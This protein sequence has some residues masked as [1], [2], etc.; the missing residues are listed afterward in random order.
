MFTLDSIERW[1]HATS[2][3]LNRANRRWIGIFFRVIS[4]LGNGRFWYAVMVTLPVL[5]GLNALRISALMMLVGII[6]AAVYAVI[7]RHTQRLR[8]CEAAAGLIITE[9][10]LDRFSFPSGHT[11]HALAFTLIVCWYYPVWG[12]VLWPFAA[13]VAMSRLIL[14]LH[15]PSD[16]LV[17][18]AI[19]TILASVGIAVDLAL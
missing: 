15:Y 10:P 8:P 19:G 12:W 2:H 13:L 3:Q 11:L 16:V 18:A 1:D 6:G 7:K 14:G 5:H 17:G 9:P 4:R